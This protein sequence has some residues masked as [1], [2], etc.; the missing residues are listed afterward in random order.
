MRTTL[1][2]IL[3][4]PSAGPEENQIVKRS[5]QLLQNWPWVLVSTGLCLLTAFIYLRYTTPVYEITSTILVKDDTKGT[6]LGEA[7]IMEN[8]GLSSGKSNIDNEVEILKSRMLIEKVVQD[9]QLFTTCSVKGNIKTTELFDQSPILLH[10]IETPVLSKKQIP[11]V[12]TIQFL[13]H[14]SLEISAT[15]ESWIV[16]PGDT[17][18]LPEG[19]A[20]VSVGIKRP[21]N[22]NTYE[23]TISGLR[24]TVHKYSQ[25]LRVSATNKQVS[26]ITIKL[27]DLNPVKG[28]AILKRLIANYLQVSQ[29]D[30]NRIAEQTISFINSNL[31]TV[32]RE[33]AALEQQMEQFRRSH[34]LADLTEQS[35]LLITDLAKY[36]SESNEIQ[37]QLNMAESLL[38][39]VKSNKNEPIPSSIILQ[40]P[41]FL[42]TISKYN[43]IQLLREKAKEGTGDAHPLMQSLNKQVADVRQELIRH[44]ESRK[45]ELDIIYQSNSSAS[46]AL[47]SQMRKIPTVERA[48]LDIKRQLQIK[49]DLHTFLLKKQI[50]TS[51]S[52]SSNLPNGRIIDAPMAD[53]YPIFPDRQIT[54]LLAL[55][56]GIFIP[57]FILSL[58]DIFN[59]RLS[60]KKELIEKVKA[61]LI[62]EIEFHRGT[63]F[64]FDRNPIAEQFR[65]LRTNLQFI[66]AG[67]KNKVILIT[68]GMS[69]EGKT[70]VATNLCQSL[71]LSGKRVILAD[72][73][74]RRPQVGKTLGLHER[75]I[76]DY[77]ISNAPLNSFTQNYDNKFSVITAGIIPPNPAE[78]IESARI[79][80]AI[81][82]LKEQYDYVIIDS[83]PFELVTDAKLLSQ[84]ADLTLYV[85]RQNFTFRHQLEAI[86]QSYETKQLPKLHI[87]LNNAKR[88]T[89][90]G[91]AYGA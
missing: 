53:Y 71:H 15:D 33:V 54:I 70:F 14:D 13:Q 67:Q 3:K 4:T 55:L 73:D 23:M 65:V 85:V 59:V 17:V 24:E 51:I 49:Q 78:L 62:G 7:A 82:E 44:I 32:S 47:K 41:V 10:F 81:T 43:E 25:A 77:A 1:E 9:L 28:E 80:Q 60:S 16:A 89:P 27:T 11:K 88:A 37:G 2:D 38:Q 8:L 68:S 52:R 21:D 6:D 26:I 34:Q 42:A 20:I 57:V 63:P 18:Q 75:G 22:D 61:P 45:S 72:F 86:Q 76:S 29:A 84:Y 39:F 30:K 91:Y 50:E 46:D 83:P 5:V 40:Q 56:S 48:F 74:L 31:D 90:Y 64:E 66:V 19:K 69:E 12:Y 58:R 35:R 87:I 79:T 36:D